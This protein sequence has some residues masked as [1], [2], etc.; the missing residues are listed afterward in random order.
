MNFARGAVV[1]SQPDAVA[2]NQPLQYLNKFFSN[3]DYLS[4][5]K[6]HSALMIMDEIY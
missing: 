3:L 5:V 2:Y 4:K 6:L 1:Y